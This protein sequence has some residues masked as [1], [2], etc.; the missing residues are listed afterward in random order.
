MLGSI[1]LSKEWCDLVFEG[2]NKAYGAY[3]IRSMAG[4]RYA[5]VCW[6]FSIVLLITIGVVG[7]LSFYV[8]RFVQQTTEEL[9]EVVKLERLEAREDFELKKISAGRKIVPFMKEGASEIAPEIV[10]EVVKT[11]PIGVDGPSEITIDDKDFVIIDKDHTHNADQRDL[12]VEGSQLTPTEVVEEMPQFPGG[13]TAL[14]SYLDENIKYA[15]YC[16]KTGVEGDVEV[17]FTVLADGSISDVDL[18]H[19]LHPQLDNAVL[20]AVRQMPI[21]KP[22]KSKGFCTPVRVTLPVHFQINS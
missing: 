8:Y 15:Q 21:W 14:M 11:S 3:E 16:I 22:G 12:P 18:V 1:L 17:K 9:E 19:G 10:D 5:I 4:H 13:L 6:F 2:R 20:A 7:V